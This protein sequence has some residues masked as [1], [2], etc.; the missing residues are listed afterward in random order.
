MGRARGTATDSF[1]SIM[2]QR[3]GKKEE[4]IEYSPVYYVFGGKPLDCF[5]DLRS[6]MNGIIYNFLAKGDPKL[7]WQAMGKEDG[8]TRI[9]VILR[10]PP[11]LSI[12]LSGDVREA[13]GEAASCNCVL[14]TY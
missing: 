3:R 9:K 2:G 10:G 11:G 8:S 1:A 7:E 14:S 12:S 4:V 5:D 6:T 13:L